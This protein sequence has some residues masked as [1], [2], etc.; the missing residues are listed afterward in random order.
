MKTTH[1]RR[2]TLTRGA[3]LLMAGGTMHTSRNISDSGKPEQIIY[4]D[5]D[6]KVAMGQKEGSYPD[7]AALAKLRPGMTKAQVRQLIG[8]PHFKEGFYFVREWDYIFHF[9][10]NG[11]V[12]TCQFKVVFDKDYLAQHYYWRDEACSVFVKKAM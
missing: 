7:G 4:P 1:F 2:L 5:P 3:C 12:R 11:L 6:S 10:S 9:P 8:S